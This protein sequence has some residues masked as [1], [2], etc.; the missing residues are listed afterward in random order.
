MPENLFTI[1]FINALE[2]GRKFYLS[3]EA[4]FH[5]MAGLSA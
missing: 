1:G 2:S 3:P 5:R 4:E